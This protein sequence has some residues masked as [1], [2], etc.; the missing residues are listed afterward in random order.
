MGWAQ[1]PY[2]SHKIDQKSEVLAPNVTSFFPFK[3]M[4]F[5]SAISAVKTRAP[6]LGGKYAFT[7]IELCTF[8]V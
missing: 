1:A 5:A 3:G 7:M 6:A 8:L 4:R 2:V